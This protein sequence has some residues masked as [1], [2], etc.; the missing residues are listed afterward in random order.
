MKFENTEVFNFEGAL[1]G[2]RNPKNSWNKSDSH[3]CFFQ[4]DEC[5]KCLNYINGFNQKYKACI[6]KGVRWEPYYIGENDM[7]LAQALI[8]AGSEHA[9]FLRQIFVSVD[10]T[11]P[12]YIWSQIDTYKIGTTA[13]ST[14]KMHRLANTPI[15]QECFEMEDYDGRIIIYNREPYDIDYDVS[16]LWADIIDRCEILRQKYNETK[17]M[18]YWKEL[19]RILPESWLQTRT[20]TANYAVLR[21]MYKQRCA[22]PHKL[23]EWQAFGSW[24]KSLPYA[25]EILLYEKEIV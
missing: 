10:I 13:N 3:L 5:E 19:I 1:R 2:M 22:T 23:T 24:I 18:R 25:K 11:A 9:K 17:D 7:K 16:E 12:E 21:N 14:S 8:A 6:D 4:N 20:W 15:T